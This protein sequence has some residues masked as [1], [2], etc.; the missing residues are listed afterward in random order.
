[1]GKEKIKIGFDL[2]G[3]IIGKPPFMSKYLMERLVRKKDHGLAYR[4]PQSKIERCIRWLSHLPPLRPPIKKN[5]KLI[6]ELY[7][8]KNYELYVVS[9]RYS[10]LEGRTKE[11]FKYYR[12]RELFKEIYINL[13]DEQPHIYKEK[14]IKKL[15]LNVFIDD[16][17]PL[18][19]YLKKRLKN[20]DLVF[21]EEQEEKFNN[22]K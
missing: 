20:V 7:K 19:E 11:W 10:F 5:I 13:K 21:V 9:S 14:M 22:L 6:H 1:M 4:F 17:R 15:K 18:L 3:V 8:S 16:D 12:L 2:D